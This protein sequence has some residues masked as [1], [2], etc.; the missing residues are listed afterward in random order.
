MKNFI[1]FILFALL[2]GSCSKDTIDPSTN[3]FKIY[4]TQRSD[5]KFRPIDIVET[6][7]GLI[8]LA[9]EATDE[10][11]YMAL[12]VLQMD[13]FGNYILETAVPGEHV[14]PVGE[15]ISIDSAYY[16]FTM[17]PTT[18]AAQLVRAGNDPSLAEVIPLGGGLQF[19]LAAN[20]TVNNQ[21]MLLSY[22]SNNQETVL[23]I[24]D[25]DGNLQAG[26]GYTIGAGNDVE[27]R[28]IEHYV[29]PERSALPFFCGPT[30][31]DSYYFN[32]FYNYSFSLVF[33]NLSAAPTGVVQGQSDHGGMAAVLPLAANTFSIFGF[34][35]NDNFIQPVQTISTTDITSSIDYFTL[36]YNE[37]ISRTPAIIRPYTAEDGTIYSIVAAESQSRSVVL[38]FY[39]IATGDLKG[40]H[41]IGYINPYTLATIKVDA[42]N[43]LLVLGTTMVSSRLSRIFVNK[44]SAGEVGSIIQ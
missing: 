9:E 20:K 26:T 14:T 19:P 33:T 37:F 10:S 13:E 6:T 8:V 32:G 17:H 44:I 4:D 30:G 35:Y 36:P 16:F 22:N 31:V 1:L 38:N 27:D 40:I 29:D 43:N 3:Y 23:S 41:S 2:M 5:A 11:Q 12:Q 39:D 42:N 7:D 21:L 25:T 34:Q 15:F 18:N 28:I 24:I